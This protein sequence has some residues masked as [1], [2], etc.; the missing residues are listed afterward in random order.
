MSKFSKWVAKHHTL[1]NILALIAGIAVLVLLKWA[2]IHPVLAFVLYFVS[3]FLLMWMTNLIV[4]YPMIKLS[5]SVGDSNDPYPLLEVCEFLQSCK[6]GNQIKTIALVNYSAMLRNIG[7]YYQAQEILTSI[8]P[9]K[10]PNPKVNKFVY[11]NNLADICFLLGELDEG[12]SW[13]EKTKEAYAEIPLKIRNNL[14]SNFFASLESQQA[15]CQKNYQK[16][17]DE[18][19]KAD[20]TK[21]VHKIDNSIL[22]AKAYVALGRTDEA[23]REL[24]F[25][26]ENGNKLYAV[27]EAK[28]LLK[29]LENE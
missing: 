28:K 11:Y 12:S 6:L 1:C 9:K 17:L 10:L 3:I 13:Y 2:G 16:V 14:R 23:K 29:E 5:A 26:I 7:R 22:R 25:V 24:N 8:D 21:L 19:S 15:Y 20:E 27:T 18:L 4:L